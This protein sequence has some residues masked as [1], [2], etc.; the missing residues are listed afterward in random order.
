MK[1]TDCTPHSLRAIQQYQKHNKRH[2][3]YG[4]PQCD[5]QTKQNKQPSIIDKFQLKVLIFK[6]LLL[7]WAML[8]FLHYMDDHNDIL[9]F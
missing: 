7:S 6:I 1:P 9:R 4:R 8:N 5:K 2:H 3:D